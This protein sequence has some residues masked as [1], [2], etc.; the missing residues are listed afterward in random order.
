[1]LMSNTKSEPEL[2]K[3]PV[4]WQGSRQIS[5]SSTLLNSSPSAQ[6]TISHFLESEERRN[7]QDSWDELGAEGSEHA[8]IWHIYNDESTK[9]DAATTDGLN[10]GIDVLLVFTGLFSAVLTTF[11]IQSYQQML[12]NPSDTTNALI[13]QLIADIRGSSLLNIT[14]PIINILTPGEDLVPSTREIHWVNGLWFAALSCSL[15]AALVSMLAKQWIQP[16]PNVSGSPRYRARQRQRRHT[17]LQNWHVFAV[18]NALPLLLHVALLLFFAGIIVLLWSGDIAITAA[19][20]AIVALAYTFYLGSMW[21][22]LIYPDCPYQHPISEQLRLWISRKTAPVPLLDLEHGADGELQPMRALMTST[23][24]D[25]DHYIDACA[26]VWLLQQSSNEDTVAATLQAIGGLPKEFTAFHVLR[27]AAAVPM[28]LQHFSSSFHRDLS[29]DLQWHVADAEGAERYCRAWVRLTHG[30]SLVWPRNLRAPLNSLREANNLH[31]AA[32]AACTIAL[33]SLESRSPQLALIYHLKAFV[34][35]DSNLN[36]LTQSWLLDTFLECS[37]SWE[38]RAAIVSDISKRAIPVLLQL[39]QRAKEMSGTPHSRITIPLILRSITIGNVDLSL[40]WDEEKRSQA[41]H[42][43]MIPVFASI[44]QNPGLY[45]VTGDVLDFSVTEFSQIAAP[46]FTRSNRFPLHIKDIARQGLSKLYLDGQVGVGLVPDWVLADILQILHPPVNVTPEQRPWFVKTL[47]H[48]LTASADLNIEIG[49]IRLLEPLLADCQSSVIRIFTE[50]N[51]IAVLLRAAHTGDT[52]SRR[53]QLDCIR[54]LCVFIKSSAA[55]YLQ[56]EPLCP[57]HSPSLEKQ[58][59]L[60]F[61]SD[62]F[63]TLISAVGAR[64]WWLAE[65]ADIWLPSLLPLC[66]IRPEEQ[67]WRRV[68]VVF[69]NFA[70]NNIGEEGSERMVDD[71]DKMKSFL[72]S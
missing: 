29:F 51:G 17:Q 15:S 40:L 61:C 62:F 47:V 14:N 6:Y 21:M 63:K 42:Q 59:N 11:I 34:K 35:G 48:T 18:I 27:D 25:P 38:L 56:E 30:T 31:A 45:G 68:E 9:T 65:I 7:I 2:L 19:T 72:K 28:V 3:S 44:V 55:C 67:I 49:C 8:R 41:F 52:D 58:F 60:I 13:A 10:R 5:T 23:T 16:I 32:I 1:M 66:Q 12:P 26:L 37:L 4:A 46:V 57:S 53:L 22:S 20:F 54:T 71:L 64:R 43:T 69:R 50:E 33:N 36:D 70:E 39:L 24:V